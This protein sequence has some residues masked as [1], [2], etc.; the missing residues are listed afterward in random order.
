VTREELIKQ[1]EA[2]RRREELVR[3]VEAKRSQKEA[4]IEEMHP[5]L[6]LTDRLIT[7]LAQSPQ[8]EAEYIQNKYPNLEVKSEGGRT[9]V[10]TPGEKQYKVLD[11]DTGAISFRSCWRRS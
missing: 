1:V 7:S 10:R 11:P 6:G 3:Q 2:K 9:L 8:K 5:D 4:P